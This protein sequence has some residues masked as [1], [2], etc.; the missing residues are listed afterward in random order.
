[1]NT[2]KEKSLELGVEVYRLVKKLPPEEEHCLSE[3]MMRATA[4][5]AVNIA[6][7]EIDSSE[8]E[9]LQ[10]LSVVRGKIAALETLILLCVRLNY[11]EEVE[12]EPVLNLCAEL[13][14]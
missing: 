1:M 8:A 10:F 4:D 9:R 3:M 13:R 7:S 11:L 14:R 5:V 12:V 6:Q 2:S